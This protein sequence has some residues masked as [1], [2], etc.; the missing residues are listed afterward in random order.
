MILQPLDL[1]R[2]RMLHA[3]GPLSRALVVSRERRVAVGGV[4]AILGA[5]LFAT[6]APMWTLALGPLLLGVPH[7]VADVRYLVLRTGL[8]R[9]RWLLAAIAVPLIAAAFGGGLRAGIIAAAL[10]LLAGSPRRASLGLLLIAPAAWIAWRS[11]A[12]A[13]A[14]FAHLHNLIAVL[15]WWGWRRSGERAGWRW[16]ALGATA[17]GVTLILAGVLDSA[18]G[19]SS[20]RGFAIEPVTHALAPGLAGA[21]ARR[22]LMLYAFGQSIHYAVWLRLVPDEDR[23]QATP[24]TWTASWRALTGDLGL[25]VVGVALGAAAVFAVWGL[26]DVTAARTAYLRSAAFHGHLEVVVLAYAFARGRLRA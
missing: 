19:L 6:R 21:W 10:A 20:P 11:P 13:D 14:V 17:L 16:L 4:V 23:K 24:R 8:V 15:L 7:I 3:L 25:T 26:F 2:L 18:G 1:V 5:F 12:R 9:E 22:A